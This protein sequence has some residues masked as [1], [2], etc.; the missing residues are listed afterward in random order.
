MAF[1]YEELLSQYRAL[2]GQPDRRRAFLARH[3]SFAARLQNDDPPNVVTGNVSGNQSP[4]SSPFSL[5]PT[6][7]QGVTLPAINPATGM[8]WDPNTTPDPEDDPDK[9]PKPTADLPE[10]WEWSWDVDLKQWVPKQGTTTSQP[11]NNDLFARLQS[12]LDFWGINNPDSSQLLKDALKNGW[13]ESEFRQNLRQSPGYL[14][15][16]LFAANVERAKQGKGW[17]DE[18]TLINWGTEAQRLAKQYGFAEPSKNYL[19]Q[20]LISGL[21]MA[22][23]EHR[24]Q[25]ERNIQEYGG[26]VRWVAENIMGRNMT[27]QDLYEVFDGEISTDDFD[28][29]YKDALYRGRPVALGLGVR[30]QA[31]ADAFRMLGVDPDEAFSRYEALGQNASRFARLGSIEDLVTRGLPENFGQSLGTEEN[32]TLVRGLLFQD[33][34]ALARLQNVIS[35]EIARFNVGGGPAAIGQG[36]LIGLQTP[37]ERAAG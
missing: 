14:A 36:Q 37:S 18:S 4:V 8:P 9:P 7:L 13:S 1:G 2:K 28:R 30:S 5:V 33:P 31:E 25:V 35:H 17:M 21:S 3:P 24:I 32:S 19:A 23:I 20:G 27:D 34:D 6:N 26:G 16:P 10:G 22:E 29:T 11:Q 12:L 15:N